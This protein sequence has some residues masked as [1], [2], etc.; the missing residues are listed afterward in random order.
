MACKHAIVT[1]QKSAMPP[2]SMIPPEDM[3]ICCICGQLRSQ[4]W[5][6]WHEPI[7]VKER[8]MAEDAGKTERQV[9]PSSDWYPDDHG[10]IEKQREGA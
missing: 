1:N 10:Q 5:G 8:T 2:E 6:P 7:D 9:T 3:Q 4:Q